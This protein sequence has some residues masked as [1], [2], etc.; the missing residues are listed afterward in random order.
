LPGFDV[1]VVLFI[2]IVRV[3]VLVELIVGV[4]IVVWIV[5][6]IVVQL[7]F[8]R[9]EVHWW[10]VPY[11]VGSVAGLTFSRLG[12]G[13]VVQ[14]CRPHRGHTQNWS[15]VHGMPGPGSRMSI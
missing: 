6:E 8:E 15:G 1:L 3:V 14:K 13:Y 12:G 11:E 7:V 5:V 4:G 10:E 2:L 9:R